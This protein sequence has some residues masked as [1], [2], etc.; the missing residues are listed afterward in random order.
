MKDIKLK[1]QNTNPKQ[2]I[3]IPEMVHFEKKNL[4]VFSILSFGFMIGSLSCY[5]FFI[6]SSI[7]YAVKTSQYEYKT[8]KIAA[9]TYSQIPEE[10]S[11]NQYSD[12]ISYI[13]IDQETAITLK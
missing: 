6:S 3:E 2:K 10:I 11:I 4:N 9:V 5:I 1:V 12:R 7:F 8:E 13:D